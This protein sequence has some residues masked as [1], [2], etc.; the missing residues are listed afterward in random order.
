MVEPFAEKGK[1]L[2]EK[3]IWLKK[4]LWMA[5]QKIYHGIQWYQFGPWKISK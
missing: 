2:E 4:R 3:K 5:N 1:E